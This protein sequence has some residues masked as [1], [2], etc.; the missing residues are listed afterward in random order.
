MKYI[1]FVF[2]LSGCA[3]NQVLPIKPEQKLL[4][5]CVEVRQPFVHCGGSMSADGV[6]RVCRPD[7]EPHFVC[8]GVK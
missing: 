4:T 6:D 1:L 2:L 7:L 8:R 5:G 3:A